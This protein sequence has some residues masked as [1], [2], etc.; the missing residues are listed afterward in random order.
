LQLAYNRYQV[1]IIPAYIISEQIP[2]CDAE[3]RARGEAV[4]GKKP[5][6]TAIKDLDISETEV[7]AIA[8]EKFRQNKQRTLNKGSTWKQMFERPYAYPST[9]KYPVKALSLWIKPQA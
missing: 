6:N 3:G 7:L 1:P 4:A 5:L 8:Q 9:H 2:T